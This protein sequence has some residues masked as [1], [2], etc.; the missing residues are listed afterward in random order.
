[1]ATTTTK[2]TGVANNNGGRILG[3]GNVAG[4]RFTNYSLVTNNSGA[5]SISTFP[6]VGSAVTQVVKGGGVAI[7]AITQSGS[8][9]YTNIQKSTHGLSVGSKIEVYGTDINS[10]NRVH[11]VTVVTDANNVKT[12][13][14]YTSN[15]ATHG[16]YKLLSGTFA[17]TLNDFI[18]V[19]I[20][21]SLAGT[22]SSL[23]RIPANR[24]Q[25]QSIA[26]GRGDYRVDLSGFN[27]IT[28]LPTYGAN[29]GVK[30][31][32]VDPNGGGALANEA[33]PTRAIPGEFVTLVTGEIPTYN[34]YKPRTE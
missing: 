20:A 28:G 21:D 17:S 8:T 27:M 31:T 14:K 22:A 5:D 7:T 12:N 34:D 4:T 26:I 16:N 1:M 9:G 2:G 13:V 30:F 25:T 6:T 24:G 18:S 19:Y 3:G 32:Y 29:R 10:Y 11:I 15:T 33:L 23:A